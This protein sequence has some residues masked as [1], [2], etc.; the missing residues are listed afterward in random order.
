MEWD[1]FKQTL[2]EN[3]SFPCDYLFK[4]VVKAATKAQFREL[5]SEFE[6]NERPSKN[7][8]FISMTFSAKVSTS[9]EIIDIYQKAAKIEGIISL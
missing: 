5:F 6:M 2:E 4:F 8:N 7:G 3:E 9:S 1:K